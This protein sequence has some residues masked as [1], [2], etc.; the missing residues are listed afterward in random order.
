MSSDGGKSS[1]RASADS[2]QLGEPV[3]WAKDLSHELLGVIIDVE[4][5]DG[6]DE[7]CLNTIK[8]VCSQ[9]ATPQQRKPL[10]TEQIWEA[11]KDL[12]EDSSWRHIVDAIE[13][14]HGIKEKNT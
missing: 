9:L 11:V 10:T 4:E 3:A 8:R 13:A 14:A 6:F 1:D 5:G 12:G 2:E 7:V